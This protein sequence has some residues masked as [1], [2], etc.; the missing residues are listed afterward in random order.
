M[1]SAERRLVFSA[2][3]SLHKASLSGA[4]TELSPVRKCLKT[5]FLHGLTRL[6][7]MVYFVLTAGIKALF[8]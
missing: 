6:I 7:V 8:H 1:A 4:V 3:R 5:A 2:E